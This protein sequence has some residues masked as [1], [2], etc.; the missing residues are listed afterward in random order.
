MWICAHSD[1]LKGT[2]IGNDSVI[3][4]G[5]LVTKKFSDSNILVAGRPAKIVK[6]SINWEE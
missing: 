3:G 5:S 1:I 2:E 4:F 6:Q